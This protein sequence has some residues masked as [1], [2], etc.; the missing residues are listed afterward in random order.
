MN[1]RK[2]PVTVYLFGNEI[3]QL[4]KVASQTGKSLSALMREAIVEKYL[5]EEKQ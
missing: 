2:S 1:N 3:E 4:E 5:G